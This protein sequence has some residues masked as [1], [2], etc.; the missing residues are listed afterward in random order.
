MTIPVLS[1]VFS[2][3]NTVIVPLVRLI[4]TMS[5]SAVL[6]APD[7]KEKAALQCPDISTMADNNAKIVARESVQ[8][9]ELT[10]NQTDLRPPQQARRHG[11]T[12]I[13]V[14]FRI[15]LNTNLSLLRP[16]LNVSL[17]AK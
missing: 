7:A 3:E 15:C 13:P 17:I 11:K 8:I 12:V 14:I 10:S 1:G 16:R 2:V 6:W 5:N 9:L 4:S